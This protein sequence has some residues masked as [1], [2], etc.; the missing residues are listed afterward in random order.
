MKHAL[1]ILLASAIVPCGQAQY[2]F[3]FAGV[4]GGPG[5]V[6]DTGSAARF[7]HPNGVAVDS[8]GN[9]YVADSGNSTIRKITPAGAVT[10]LAGSAGQRGSAD[11]IGS[12]AQFKDPAGVAVDSAGNVY[13]ADSSNDTIRKITPA[14][15]VTTLAGSPW[16]DYYAD[17][18][19]SAA[20]FIHPNGV[21]VDSTGNVYVTDQANHTIRKITPAGEVTTL[22]GSDRQEGYADGTGSVARFNLPSGVAVD[23]AG[24]VY[25]ADRGNRTI[26]KITPAGAVTTLAGTA[27]QAGSDD[28]I[29]SAARFFGPTGVAADSAGNV[30]VA[31]TDND[32]IR[33]ITPA[34]AVTTLAG[35]A[36]VAL[37]FAQ[38]GTGSAARLRGPFGVASHVSARLWDVSTGKLIQ[39]FEG[40]N[41]PVTAMAFSPDGSNILTGSATQELRLWDTATGKQIQTFQ[42]GFGSDVTALVFSADGQRFLVGGN[43]RTLE[44]R[45][46]RAG[47]VIQT[48][49]EPRTLE[50]PDGKTIKAPLGVGAALFVSDGQ[51]VLAAGGS[52]T[53][54]TEWET[55]TGKQTRI[56]V[57][58]WWSGSTVT[59][60][61]D[62]KTRSWW[63]GWTGGSFPHELKVPASSLT[64][65]FYD[66]VAISPDAKRAF[67][68]SGSS[69]GRVAHWARLWDLEAG[70]IIW[71]SK[72]FPGG[73]SSFGR[74][75]SSTQVAFSPDG[76][77]FV[78]GSPEDG[79]RLWDATTG[80][81]IRT[82]G[83]QKQSFQ[84]VAFS[85]SGKTILTWGADKMM[86][87]WDAQTG[88]EIQ[89][90]SVPV[91]TC[92]TFSPDGTKILTGGTGKL[93]KFRGL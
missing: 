30:Y 20:G 85:P 29:R 89:S 62:G 53:T 60:T 24:N 68:W 77:Q 51:K 35:T 59:L 7:D 34:G 23:S 54:V 1:M 64:D 67:T 25:V 18:T 71:F 42:I 13:V 4:P 72:V 39:T 31:D 90:F 93:G 69:D 49:G 2:A 37:P 45:D 6:D 56:F 63:K 52:D 74:S 44:L 11:G 91:V 8:A 48:F 32:T 76:T 92:V 27:G 83:M 80:E 57:E 22:A 33:K 47:Q 17:G 66:K 41:P 87:L 38:D 65:G 43:Q 19:G 5:N 78:T 88:K 46:A 21:A 9:V 36:R 14:G 84:W 10:T 86:R 58:K 81:A 40:Y 28:G 16:Q 82:F 55:A 70:K 50:L 26:R 15:V 79:A 3:N 75:P 61:A 73:A 12:A